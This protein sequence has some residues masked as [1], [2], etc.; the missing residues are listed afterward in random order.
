MFDRIRH[1]AKL[2]VLLGLA[3]AISVGLASGIGERRARDL[4]PLQTA[5]APPLVPA[6]ATAA[7]ADLADSGTAPA[8]ST[9]FTSIAATITPGVVRIE[10][11]RMPER[12]RRIFSQRLRSFIDPD[13]STEQQQAPEVAGGSG[14]IVSTDGYIVTNNH[15]VE[16][17][18]FIS[19]RLFDKRSLPARLVGRDP[20]TDVALLKVEATG[21]P[22]LRFGDSDRANVGEWVLAIGNPGFGDANTL[23]FTVTSGIISAK[24]RPLEVLDPM[25]GSDALDRFAIEDFIQTDAAI[26]PGNSGG[27]LLNLRG[28]VVGVNTAIASSTGYNQGYAFA[29]PANLVQRVIK[30]LAKHGHVRRPLLG[31]Q[32][33]DITQEDAEVF[34][35]PDISGVLVED[36][37]EHSPAET[38]GL[39]RGD[40]IVALDGQK[41]ERVG[42]LQRL[43]ADHAP[44]ETVALSVIRYGTKRNFNIRLTQA[45]LPVTYDAP[46]RTRTVQGAGRLGIQVVELNDELAEQHGFTASGGAVI[47]AVQ[48]G[49]AA[50]RKRFRAPQRIVEINRK[51]IESARQAQILLRGLNSGDVV[52]LLL[53]D[54]AGIT[55]IINI[56]VP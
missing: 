56:R 17:A 37:S 31:V 14:F 22:A 4:P 39:Q 2:L 5:T 27:P 28:D 8:L 12:P 48:P 26:N 54:A 18:D 15:V 53:E 42:Q 13:S 49:S 30:D 47:T 33:Q 6:S 10:A 44:G 52:S 9:A 24:G 25:S 29:I 19:V 34:K 45:Q 38:S 20:F 55:A 21:L 46:R 40:V 3:L 1:N 23:D 11:E 35:L 51:K 41:I 50:G 32:I 7:A 36:F 43:I 16:G